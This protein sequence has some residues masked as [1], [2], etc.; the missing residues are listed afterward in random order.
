MNQIKQTLD[1]LRKLKLSQTK[2]RTIPSKREPIY[3]GYIEA[4]SKFKLI[5]KNVTSL[6]MS[7]DTII[8]TDL[9]KMFPNLRDLKIY[10]YQPVLEGKFSGLTK[11][12]I[13]EYISQEELLKIVKEKSPGFMLMA[14]VQG[15]SLERKKE[16]AR[17]N[18]H[19]ILNI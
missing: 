17:Q 1:N 8:T 11:V 2:D 13:D 5:F 9:R 16:L 4:L 19:A 12:Q 6:D 3:S 14:I 18:K 7:E 15:V 10:R